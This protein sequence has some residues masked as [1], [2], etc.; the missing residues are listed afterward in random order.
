[1]F[2]SIDGSEVRAWKAN[3]QRQQAEKEKLI[4]VLRKRKVNNVVELRRIEKSLAA[5]GTID[6]TEPMTSACMYLNL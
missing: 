2:F 5:I 3:A 4:E 1:M 6:V